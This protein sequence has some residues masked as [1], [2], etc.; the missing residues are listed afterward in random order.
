MKTLK[1]LSVIIGLSIILF[2]CGDDNEIDT[3]KPEIDITIPEAFPTSCNDTIYFGESFT[4]KFRLTDNTELGSYSIDIHH[5]FDHHSH[6]TEVMECNLN[7]K[8]TPENPYILIETYD[9]P[10]G[11]NEYIT[12]LPITIPSSNTS[13]ELYDEGDY[14]FNLS[15]T[16]QEGWTTQFG[17]GIKMMHR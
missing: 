8:K 3:E 2:S 17:I 11:K 16:D 14:H 13:G 1:L 12:D 6:S 15:V 4:I 5:N 7:P 9:I 10:I